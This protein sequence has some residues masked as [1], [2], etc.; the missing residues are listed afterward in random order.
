MEQITFGDGFYAAENDGQRDFRWMRRHAVITVP[1]PP[2]GKWL[3]L[4]C[5]NPH[6]APV[7]VSLAGTREKQYSLEPGW[8]SFTLCLDDVQPGAD[9]TV[10]LSCAQA[11]QVPGD[12]RE[13]ALMVGE[14]AWAR[15]EGGVLLLDGFYAEESDNLR[16]FRWMHNKARLAVT[17]GRPGQWLLFY[18]KSPSAWAEPL[19]LRDQKTDARFP[20][21]HVLPG[22]WKVVGWPIEEIGGEGVFELE[23]P[24]TLENQNVEDRRPLSFMLSGAHVGIPTE[25]EKN[26]AI[27]HHEVFKRVKTKSIGTF[28]SCDTCS[29]CNLKCVFCAL[30]NKLRDKNNEKGINKIRTDAYEII[31]KCSKVQP[32]ITGEP[33]CGKDIWDIVEKVHDEQKF[34]TVELEISTNGLLINEEKLQKILRSG[35]TSLLISVNAATEKTYSRLV[36]GDFNTLLH[37]IKNICDKK[38]DNPALRISLSYVLMRENIDEVLQF[39]E[40]SKSLG[41]DSIQIWPLNRIV[42]NI[43]DKVTKND[44]TFFYEQQLPEYYPN[45]VQK[46]LRGV[47][48]RCG[49]LHL[50]IGELPG[51]KFTDLNIHDIP[52]PLEIEVFN[53]LRGREANTYTHSSNIHMCYYPW[54]EICI[55]TEGLFAPCIHLLYNGGIDNI[56][57]KEF[58][59]VWNSVQMQKMRD[60]IIN[61]KIPDI[62][63]DAQCPYV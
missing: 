42:K 25:Y 27:L 47:E 59:S 53:K 31:K 9:G 2:T 26:S 32:Y 51:Y 17:G 58:S 36:G 29:T 48:N 57:G 55:T 49:E 34:R 54:Y 56:F 60:D 62:C 50:H 35:I 18:I 40:L 22:E 15:P 43:S 1:Q 16:S 20:P 13:L 6:G 28:F 4:A 19:T 61:W 3:R 37:N 30:D 46:V 41:A 39:V 7:T 24:Y 33:F 45:I 12:A 10:R 38:N 52:Y 21:I 5:A 44:F 14:I 11:L 63:K 8:T 23:T